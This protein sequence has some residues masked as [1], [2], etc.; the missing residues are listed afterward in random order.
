MN[1]AGVIPAPSESVAAVAAERRATPMHFGFVDALRGFAILGVMMIHASLWTNDFEGRIKGI[2][3]QGMYGVQLFFVVS[4]FTLFWSLRS[5]SKVER[6]PLAAFYT[7]RIFRIGPLFWGAILFYCWCYGLLHHPYSASTARYLATRA[8]N[9][10]SWPQILLTAIFL[11]GWYPTTVN[12]IVPG[13]W[14]IAAEFCFYLTIP[15][16]FS[17][18]RSLSQALWLTMI[19][20]LLV[21]LAEGPAVTHLS[22]HFPATENWEIV[23]RQFVDETFLNQF[24]V[25]CLG[26]V[27]YFLLLPRL[28]EHRHGRES[29][30]RT[31]PR[32]CF[33][34]SSAR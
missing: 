6:A 23:L 29:A 26:L 14:S 22:H 34:W 1:G 27:L 32:H 12:V 24:P 33:S 31:N 28:A 4:A 2:A 11:H 17:R 21:G 13:G 25:F 15:L 19:S 7:R 16:L 10:V 8:P 30:S 18:I 20:T 3:T 9:G 5:R